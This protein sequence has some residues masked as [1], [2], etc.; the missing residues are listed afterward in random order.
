M[1]LLLLLWHLLYLSRLNEKKHWVYGSKRSRGC[2]FCVTAI[3]SIPLW[4]HDHR[5]DL[6]NLSVAIIPF[7]LRL[8]DVNMVGIKRHPLICQ[9]SGWSPFHHYD[10]HAKTPTPPKKSLSHSRTLIKLQVHGK[11]GNLHVETSKICHFTNF[12]KWKLLLLGQWLDLHICLCLCDG[13]D[14]D[15]RFLSYGILKVF[16]QFLH[17]HLKRFQIIHNASQPK[18]NYSV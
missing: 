16:R 13:V 2:I 14:W 15:R 9:M 5:Q 18:I 4:L 3:I 12:T 1:A 6:H 17:L 11:N 8:A 7:V 10:L